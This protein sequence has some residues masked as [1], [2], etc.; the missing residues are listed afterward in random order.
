[1]GRSLVETG[2][3]GEGTSEGKNEDTDQTDYTPRTDG[4]NQPALPSGGSK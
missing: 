2:T 4:G 1:M 3:Q